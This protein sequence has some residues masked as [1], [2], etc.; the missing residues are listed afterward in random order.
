M[1]L[2]IISP[3]RETERLLPRCEIAN[4]SLQPPP[5]LALAA[6][7]LGTLVLAQLDQSV[8]RQPILP[9]EHELQLHQRRPRLWQHRAKFPPVEVHH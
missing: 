4:L 9:R 6:V 8:R 3:L 5:Q 2:I 7:G 1:P